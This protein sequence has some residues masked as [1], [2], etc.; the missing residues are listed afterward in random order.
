LAGDV[1]ATA[2]ALGA[3]PPLRLVGHSLGGRVAL[4]AA[5]MEPGRV[6]RVALLDIGPSALPPGATEAS[7][8]V[9]VLLAAPDD[10]ADR[11]TFR[12]HFRA[13]GLDSAL[14]EWLLLNLTADGGR[15][16]WAVDRHALAALH[17]RTSAEDLWAVVEGPRPWPLECVRG[18]RSGY[19]S[20]S[21]AS[22]LEAAGSSVVTIPDAGHFLHVERPAEVVA[23]LRAGLGGQASGE[24]SRA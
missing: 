3:R 22:R 24:E 11:D 12:A 7:R 4:R 20:D 1:F 9:E 6:G 23:A 21:D 2:E 5:G 15:Y 13:S 17:A 10:V 19:V 18:G 8:V 16:R 14:T